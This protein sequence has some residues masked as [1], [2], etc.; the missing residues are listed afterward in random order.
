MSQWDI[1]SAPRRN[2]M[3]KDT[4]RSATQSKIR[5]SWISIFHQLLTNIF[6]YIHIIQRLIQLNS[7]YFIM[8]LCAF[9]FFICLKFFRNVT[10]VLL[11]FVVSC[12]I[13]TPR[14]S[15]SSLQEHAALLT[16]VHTVCKDSEVK[17]NLSLM[18]KN[19]L[20]PHHLPKCIKI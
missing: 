18:F 5:I 16:F 1:Y 12:V 20:I 8:P 11:L 13:S 14:L 19:P 3:K 9:M 15:V 10:E 7:I 17:L 4:K 2:I 6:W